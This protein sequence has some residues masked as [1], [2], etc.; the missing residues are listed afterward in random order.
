MIP[1]LSGTS[2]RSGT[3]PTSQKAGE[4]V[5]ELVLTS[6]ETDWWSQSFTA[7]RALK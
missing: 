6:Q 7:M 1:V 4:D 5:I 2:N 3:G